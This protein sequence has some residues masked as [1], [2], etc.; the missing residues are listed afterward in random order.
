VMATIK[1]FNANNR[2]T[3]ATRSRG[4][5]RAAL[6]IARSLHCGDSRTPSSVAKVA[7]CHVHAIQPRQHGF[8]AVRAHRQLLMRD[9]QAGPRLPRPFVMSDYSA[10]PSTLGAA[11]NGLDQEQPGG[12]FWGPQLGAAVNKRP[13][14]I[15]TLD[16]KVRRILRR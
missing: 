15:Q 14:A 1:H 13:V 3:T 12:T 2:S 8:Y 6:V 16:D 10:T 4:G 9:P 11:N 5:G 7:S